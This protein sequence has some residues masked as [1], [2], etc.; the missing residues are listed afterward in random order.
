MVFRKGTKITID[1]KKGFKRKGVVVS[2][3][4][5]ARTPLVIRLTNGR[6]IGAL[7]K[8]VKRRKK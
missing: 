3:K 6:L 4:A 8:D 7:P 1:D 2:S 5:K